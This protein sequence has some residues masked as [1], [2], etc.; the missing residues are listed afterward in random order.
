[1]WTCMRA[2]TSEGGGGG[3][4]SAGCCR[5][6]A[7]GPND[8]SG[9]ACVQHNCIASC[10]SLMGCPCGSAHAHPPCARRVAV[11]SR[12]AATSA[13][14]LTG[15]ASVPATA[16]ASRHSSPPSC[17]PPPP[18]PAARPSHERQQLNVKHQRRVAHPSDG[19]PPVRQVWR[20]GDAAHLPDAHPAHA[21]IPPGDDVAGAEDHGERPRAALAAALKK[22]QANVGPRIPAVTVTVAVAVAVAIAAA[23]AGAAVAHRRHP[24]PLLDVP[25]IVHLTPTAREE[26]PCGLSRRAR[27]PQL[28]ANLERHVGQPRAVDQP[29]PPAGGELHQHG[30]AIGQRVGNERAGQQ[31]RVRAPPVAARRADEGRAEDARVDHVRAVRR[32]V[33]AG[34]QF[35]PKGVV[36]VIVAPAAGAGGG[37]GGRHD[38]TVDDGEEDDHNGHDE[39]DGH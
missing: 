34:R 6:G 18:G 12:R 35:R 20:H 39:G 22:P 29:V 3:G 10:C 11:A 24:P 31:A 37:A 13:W 8:A 19:A 30:A 27:P 17:P 36:I 28:D 32:A 4:C 2:F 38:R 23:A 14:L 7:L 16:P 21:H 25:V 33:G 1:M 15:R 9:P 5:M 26:Q